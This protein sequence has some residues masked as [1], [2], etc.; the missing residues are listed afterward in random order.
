MDSVKDGSSQ[1]RSAAARDAQPFHIWVWLLK[2]SHS[3]TRC[4]S[5][6]S[7]NADL[8]QKTRVQDKS[9][10]DF[11]PRLPWFPRQAPNL[12]LPLLVSDYQIAKRVSDFCLN[13]SRSK[14]FILFLVLFL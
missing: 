4:P 8:D 7:P 2:V 5:R 1:S 13:L 3:W 12:S 14:L 10:S 9:T 11:H 6:V